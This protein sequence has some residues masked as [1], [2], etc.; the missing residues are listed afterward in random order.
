MSSRR[1]GNPRVVQLPAT[2]AA[3]R[4]LA[5][6]SDDEYRHDHGRDDDELV[7]ADEAERDETL[8]SGDRLRRGQ[9]GVHERDAD[10]QPDGILPLAHAPVRAATRPVNAKFH[11]ASWFEL[12]FEAGRRQA[13]NQLA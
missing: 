5:V 7:Q 12:C 13:S 6:F 9:S 4:R 8:G 11:Y 3:R 1:V 10:R 2:V